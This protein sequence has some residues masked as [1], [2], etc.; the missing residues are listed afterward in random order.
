MFEG[1]GIPVGN[2]FRRGHSERCGSAPGDA[3]IYGVSVSGLVV[4]CGWLS[5]GDAPRGRCARICFPRS[6][7]CSFKCSRQRVRMLVFTGECVRVLG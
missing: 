2:R 5:R 1:P 7:R 4:G 3:A 6:S